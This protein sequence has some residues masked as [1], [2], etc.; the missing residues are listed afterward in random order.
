MP[1]TTLSFI[2]FFATFFFVYYA[3]AKRFQW[4]LLLTGSMVFYGYASPYYLLLLWATILV[5]FVGAVAIGSV[6]H[7][8]DEYLARHKAELSRDEKK[9]CK[10]KAE[11][12]AKRWLVGTILVLVLM[13]GVF[14]YAQFAIDNLFALLGLFGIAAKS[15]LTFNVLLPVGLSF[16]VFQSMGYCIDVYREEVPPERNLFKYALFVSFFPQLLQGPIGNYGRLTP[17]LLAGYAFDYQEVVFGLQRVAWGFFK[18]LMIAN[19]IADR[20]NSV[21]T[22]VSDYSGMIC[23]SAVLF[24]YAVQLYADFSGY[25]DIACGC[26]QMLGIKL[27][28]NF[29]CPYFSR[30]IAEFWRNWHITLGVW[31]K[32][33]V[34]YPL[35]RGEILTGIRKRLKAYVYL[36]NVV[37]TICALF[38]VWLLIGLWHGADWSYVVYGLYHGA[39]IMVGIALCS[40]TDRFHAL[41]PRLTQSRLYFA[42][43][44][45]R[46]FLIVMVGYAIFKPV[47]L[48]ATA[49][50]CK[51]AFRALDGGGVY[52]LQYTLHHS[53]IKVF[54]WMALM[55]V[56]DVIHYTHEKGTI[57]KW[58]HQ[59]PCVVRWIFYVVALWSMI[60]FGLYGSGFDQF[61]YFK[62]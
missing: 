43:Q 61:E 25:M 59:L 13:L 28:E 46:T 6:Y 35:L 48:S 60:F 56:V 51:Q 40:V 19:I 44:V 14:K 2:G 53:F 7:Q 4:W 9:T 55:F 42:F 54:V 58:L 11:A 10:A 18:K 5:T 15:D 29:R 26:S 49:S 1:F 33:Y 38:I 32:N 34:F 27:D 57:R 31:F 22:N 20:I 52:Q 45:F 12:N 24:L 36:A 21:W 3:I 8:R 41:F 50:I 17:Q 37:P 23:W 39:F 16:Y 62:F 47:D 30:S